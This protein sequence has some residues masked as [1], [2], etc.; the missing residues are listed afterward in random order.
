MSSPNKFKSLYKFFNI[1]I[2]GRAGQ[3]KN[4]AGR[5]GYFGPVD[6]TIW[7]YLHTHGHEILRCNVQLLNPLR[8]NQLWLLLL[9]PGVG[10]HWVWRASREGQSELPLHSNAT[11]RS[12]LRTTNRWAYTHSMAVHF[13]FELVFH[14]FTT[15]SFTV[16]ALCLEG[17]ARR[18]IL[19]A[20]FDREMRYWS[21]FVEGKWRRCVQLGL[22]LYLAPGAFR[23][24][25]HQKDRASCMPVYYELLVQEPERWMRR[26]YEFIGLPFNSDVLRHEVFIRNR[27]RLSQYEHFTKFI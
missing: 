8:I 5:A 26:V 15:R 14:Y 27:T 18:K 12:L 21:A 20:S 16:S 19:N 10:C 6:T 7:Y 4:F 3:N 1:L 17:L 11:R 25:Q 2:A 24:S 23:G 9:N 22:H 13:P